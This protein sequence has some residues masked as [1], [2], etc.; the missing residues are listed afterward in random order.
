MPALAEKYRPSSWDEVIGQEKVIARVRQLAARGSLAARAYWLSG[1]S[2]TGKT[3]IAKLIAAEV[4][5][6]FNTEELDAATLTVSD[7]VQI[8]REMQSY[9]LGCKHGRAFL[10]NE[11]HALRKPVIRQLLVLLERIPKHVAI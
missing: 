9:G 2:G 5:D 4:A 7:L 6:D 11:S 8:E 3:T 1:Q 10:V